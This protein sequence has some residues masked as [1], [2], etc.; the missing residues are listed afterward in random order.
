MLVYQKVRQYM[1]E[2]GIK[3]KNV[4][5]SCNFNP[6]TFNAMLNGKRKMYADDLRLICYALNVS[7]EIFINCEQNNV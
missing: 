1:E 4:A 5:E 2:H 7:P 6:S 3:Q